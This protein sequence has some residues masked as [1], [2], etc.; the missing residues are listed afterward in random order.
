M[1]YAERAAHEDCGARYETLRRSF[2]AL[3]R[4]ATPEELERTVPASPSWRVRD[5]LAH[6]AGL[7]EDLNRGDLGPGD[8]EAWTARQVDRFR[9]GT[10]EDVVTVWDHEAPTFE[11]GLRLFGYQVGN[12]F[13]GDLF[14]HLTD[15]QVAL[16][17][18][19]DRDGTAMW[20]ALDWYL[21]SLGDSLSDAHVGALAV[22]TGIETRVV[23]PG[24]VAADVVVEPFEMLRACAGR[25]TTDAIAAYRWSGDVDAFIGRISRYDTPTTDVGV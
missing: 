6:V 18:P 22:E 25:R 15:V 1:S 3:A 9:A 21:D 2:I 16:G 8:P 11:D 10:V 5:V 23:G 4:T 24:D 12:H 13:V 7:T 17:R 19:V 20:I 14:I